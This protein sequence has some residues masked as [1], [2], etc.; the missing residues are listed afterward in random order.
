[1]CNRL[2]DAVSGGDSS[3][4]TYKREH[5][6]SFSARVADKQ[7]SGK[8]EFNTQTSFAQQQCN[9]HMY[10]LQCADSAHS[11]NSTLPSYKLRVAHGVP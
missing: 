8:P 7:A 10:K 3:D 6:N 11:I 1:M 9:V 2:A 4:T 5:K